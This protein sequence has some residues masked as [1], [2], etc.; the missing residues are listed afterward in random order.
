MNRAA[1]AFSEAY[2]KPLRPGQRN[3]F[4]DLMRA[5]AIAEVL[6]QHLVDQVGPPELA[7]F[8]RAPVGVQLFLVLSGWLL[9]GQLFRAL[10]RDGRLDVARFWGRRWLR[11]LP[12]YYV[13]LAVRWLSGR[14][15]LPETAGM[16]VFAQNY[17]GPDAWVITWSLC[18]QEHLYVALPFVLLLTARRPRLGIV[19]SVL[20]LLLSPALRWYAFR[21]SLTGSEYLA[22]IEAPTHMRLDGVVVG[23]LLAALS[24]RGGPVWEWCRR[25]APALALTGVAIIGAIG[26]GPWFFDPIRQEAESAS[27]CALGILGLSVGAAMLIPSTAAPSSSRRW[28]HAPAMWVADHAYVLYLLHSSIYRAVLA[29]AKRFDLP[30]AAS[31]A[32]AVAVTSCAGWALRTAVEKPALRARQ[33]LLDRPR[34]TTSA[35]S[36]ELLLRAV[37]VFPPSPVEVRQLDAEVAVVHRERVGE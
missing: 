6:L 24:E 5:V 29:T 32:A 2:V 21:P 14:T 1:I 26:A 16:L 28:W 30:V 20:S 7:R 4:I 12:A 25:H 36:Q 23:V 11:T 33:W 9:G 34:E 35:P 15:A 19:L 3:A 37:P 22:I 8:F 13:V 17:V 18:V 31:A 10:A 27:A